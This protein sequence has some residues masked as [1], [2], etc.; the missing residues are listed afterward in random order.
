MAQNKQKNQK[1][2]NVP[3]AFALPLPDLLLGLQYSY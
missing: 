3:F 2:N 1:I